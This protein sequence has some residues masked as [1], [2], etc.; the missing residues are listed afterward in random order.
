MK[1]KNLIF[2]ALIS[3]IL[4]SC[5]SS[6]YFQVYKAT[7]SEQITLKERMMVYEDENCKVSYNLWGEGG[8]MGFTFFN[9]TDKNI[10][11]NK[12]E[13]FFVL[14]GVSYNYYLNRVFTNSKSN[15]ESASKG[16]TQEKYV[17]GTNNL[18]LLQTDKTYATN[19]TNA[20]TSTGY[21]VSYNE[22]KITCIPAMTSKLI[23]EYNINQTLFRDCELFLYPSK[24]Q[25]KAITFE[26]IDSP[27][28]FSNRILYTIG[29]SDNLIKLENEFYVTEISNYPENEMIG[30]KYK[31]Y[32]GQTSTVPTK[33]FYEY[34]PD[35][36][37]IKY[38]N[39]PD[40]RKH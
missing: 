10:Y 40:G 23:S 21:S 9:K 18:G 24:K 6:T 8:N 37:Y 12:E 36:F 33:Y 31:E 28:V 5:G 30:T 34:S 1:T 32:C 39:S 14:N 2:A 22:E 19:S 26:K 25:I 7:P 27:L 38:S 16:I 4:T 29:R 20:M 35:K 17:S 11:I 3:V 15:A 13:C